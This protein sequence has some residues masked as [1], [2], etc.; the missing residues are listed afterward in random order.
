M[1]AYFMLNTK[2]QIDVRNCC[3]KHNIYYEKEFGFT[4]VIKILIEQDE[5]S[6]VKF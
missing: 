6:D 1:N 2:R 3:L 5:F 4:K